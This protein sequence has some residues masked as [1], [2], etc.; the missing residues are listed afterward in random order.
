[1]VFL[2]AAAAG[3]V[4]SNPKAQPSRRGGG[5]RRELHHD[6]DLPKVQSERPRK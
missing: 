1:M 3:A 5:D 2:G 4:A 6:V